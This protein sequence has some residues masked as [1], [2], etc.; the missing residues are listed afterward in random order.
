MVHIVSAAETVEEVVMLFVFVAKRLAFTELA[1]L[2]AL[3]SCQISL[4]LGLRLVAALV[5]LVV[6]H[7]GIF[8]KVLLPLL[9]VVSVMAPIFSFFP[10]WTCGYH[11][12]ITVAVLNPVGVGDGRQWLL[13]ALELGI[14]APLG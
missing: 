9:N 8:S 7:I 12:S 5:T 14:M 11:R 2:L 10:R 3:L 6:C 13:V 4:L 1:S